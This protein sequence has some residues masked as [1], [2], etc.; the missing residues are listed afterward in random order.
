MA[1]MCCR[2]PAASQLGC[3]TIS[4]GLWQAF[5][6]GLWRTFECA[7]RTTVDPPRLFL[8]AAS[9]LGA[10]VRRVVPAGG[11]TTACQPATA[12]LDAVLSQWVQMATAHPITSQ[13]T[14]EPCRGRSVPQQAD[15]FVDALHQEECSASKLAK[16]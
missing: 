8:E 2:Q 6:C 12:W 5:V 9:A 13:R 3:P 16:N 10:L 4:W 1:G 11:L 7:S 14:S 15:H